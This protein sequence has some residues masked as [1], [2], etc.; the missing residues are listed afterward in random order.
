MAGSGQHVEADFLEN[1]VG[2]AHFGVVN[3]FLARFEDLFTH[4][5]HLQH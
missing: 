3:E 5:V 1:K 2:A 4:G